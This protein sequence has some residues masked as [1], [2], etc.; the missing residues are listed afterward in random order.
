MFVIGRAARCCAGIWV[1]RSHSQAYWHYQ[2]HSFN[3]DS[4]S[5]F[6][7]G[8]NGLE[9][10][11][12]IR[13]GS[14]NLDY[15]VGNSEG[16]KTWTD[17]VPLRTGSGNIGLEQCLL[18]I[19]TQRPFNPFQRCFDLLYSLSEHFTKVIKVLQTPLST[20]PAAFWTGSS[21]LITVKTEFHL[22][23]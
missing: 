16:A 21:F 3:S 15:M 23:I 12:S 17:R 8:L 1:C 13:A 18:T 6:H 19:F 22:P 7:Q 11:F 9:E 2:I 20:H 5:S 4:S 10:C 14:K